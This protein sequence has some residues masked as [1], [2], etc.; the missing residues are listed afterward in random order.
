VRSVT[1]VTFL[2]TDIEGSPTAFFAGVITAAV[3]AV[4]WIVGA[5]MP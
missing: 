2:F 5:I 3:G 4:T 1:T